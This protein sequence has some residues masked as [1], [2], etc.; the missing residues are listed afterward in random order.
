MSSVKTVT[1]S[2]EALNRVME[3]AQRKQVELDKK[4]IKMNVEIAVKSAN[5]PDLGGNLDITA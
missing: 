4:M 3:T 5:V 1:A 2:V